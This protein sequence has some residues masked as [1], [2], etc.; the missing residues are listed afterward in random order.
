LVGKLPNFSPI[1]FL[2]GEYEMQVVKEYPNG[3]FCWVDLA[4]T[5]TAA[6]TAFYEGLFGWETVEEPLPG[7]GVYLTF[8]K[9]GMRVA[10]GGQMDPAMQEQGIPPFW[11]SYVK[12]DDAD[13]IAARIT[14]A[15]GTVMFP[16]MDIMEE[17]R[18]TVA[19]DP[20]GAMFG[21]WQPKNHTGAQLVNQPDTLSWNELQTTDTGQALDFYR[22]VFGWR[23]ETADESG[24]V[25]LY[26]GD[27][28]QAGMIPMDESWEGVP[29]NWAVYFNVADV[30]ASAA[31][32]ESLGGKL[33]MP[34]ADAGDV[35]R[36]T[37]VQD[38]QGGMFSIIQFN[39]PAS[40]PPG[41]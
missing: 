22:H 36:F 31:K 4:T 15:G 19:Q 18:M 37:I 39:G 8:Q 35:G 27:R 3:V 32:A 13:A 20:T 33:L 29:P 38:P 11:T 5:D 16:P 26:A 12:H 24:Y 21:V 41:Y 40:P 7:E 1:C 2:Q 10:G 23:G 9:D 25:S 14:E 30:E 6:A 17:G 28:S 34:V